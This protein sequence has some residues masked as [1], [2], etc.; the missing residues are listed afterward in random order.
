MSGFEEVLR[1]VKEEAKHVKEE[2]KTK[3]NLRTNPA[4]NVSYAKNMIIYHIEELDDN[5]L[6]DLL[7][8]SY[9]LLLQDIFEKD[10]TSYLDVMI[11]ERL[12]TQFIRVI[13][14]VNI[15]N[16]ETMYCNKLAYDYLTRSSK[17]DGIR[18]LML[19]MSKAVNKTMISQLHS[20]GLS[21]EISSYLALSRSSSLKE[22]VNVR[23]V[24][25]ILLNYSVDMM[26]PQ[27]II[28]I[29]EKLF[30]VF[31]DLFC[32][33][34]FDVYEREVLHNISSDASEIYSNINL[35]LVTMLEGQESQVIRKVFLSYIGNYSVKDF[36]EVRFPIRSLAVADFKRILQVVDDL[37]RYEMLLVP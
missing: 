10:E 21:D 4:L 20:I 27:M 34:M 7:R 26:T 6:H 36:T 25:H 19:S 11:S 32:A 17:T 2:Q 28:N 37:E 30:D 15:D 8:Q 23:R 5:E 29:F 22:F 12:L 33:T 35:A 1:Q 24:N 9:K 18:K 16:L 13:N 14:S 3:I 31:S